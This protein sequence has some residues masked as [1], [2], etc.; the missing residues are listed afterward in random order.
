MKTNLHNKFYCIQSKQ[1]FFD[2]PRIETKFRKKNPLRNSIERITLV[3]FKE[4]LAG[5]SSLAVEWQ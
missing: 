2:P 5:L 1:F 3:K 4:R